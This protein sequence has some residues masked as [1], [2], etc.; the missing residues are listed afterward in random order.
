MH[1]A[2]D[3]DV[4]INNLTLGDGQILTYSGTD[5]K[6]ENKDPNKRLEGLTDDVTI[7]SP[8]GGQLL[9]YNGTSN[10]W[11]NQTFAYNVMSI[12][13]MQATNWYNYTIPTSTLVDITSN[14]VV[15]NS[16]NSIISSPVWTLGT[17]YL[18]YLPYSQPCCFFINIQFSPWST[19]Q[20][21][22]FEAWCYLVVNNVVSD[23]IISSLPFLVANNGTVTPRI[24]QPAQ[25][26]TMYSY[27]GGNEPLTFR[28]QINQTFASSVTIRIE[29][30]EMTIITDQRFVPASS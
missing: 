12:G 5:T 15:L 3:T 9:T 14:P 16:N 2:D 26:T 13:Q 11:T 28:L 30:Y 18:N 4:S 29:V 8:S 19:D 27:A 7:T 24:R 21:V 10:I 23:T 22:D 25:L 20:T 17:G 6:W 1:L